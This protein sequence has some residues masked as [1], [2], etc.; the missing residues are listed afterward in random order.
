MF[1]QRLFLVLT[2]TLFS[3]SNSP[4]LKLMTPDIS[5][6]ST[7]SPPFCI[8]EGLTRENRNYSKVTFLLLPEPS[9]GATSACVKFEV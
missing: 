9:E 5:V 8:H 4:E 6:E 7:V 3:T 1:P 2:M